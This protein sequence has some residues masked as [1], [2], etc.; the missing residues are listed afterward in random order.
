MSVTVIGKLVLPS[1]AETVDVLFG[2]TPVG[3]PTL[4]PIARV[5]PVTVTFTALLVE[6]AV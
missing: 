5:F 1:D 6:L 3:G 4:R 2:A